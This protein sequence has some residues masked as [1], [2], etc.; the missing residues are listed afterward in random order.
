MVSNSGIWYQ[1]VSDIRYQTVSDIRYQTVSDIRY[2]TVSDIRYQTVSDIRYQ[3]VSDIRY[4][5]VSDIW[6]QTVSDIRYQTVTYCRGKVKFT[7][8]QATKAQRRSKGISPLFL[9]PRRQMGV[10]GQRHA[11][12]AL[13]PGKTHCIGGWVGPRAGLDRFGISRLHRHSIPDRPDRSESLYR[14]SY[15]TV[16]HCIK[17]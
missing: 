9:Q 1:T 16:T 15:P 2:Q 6:Y 10:G 8:E 3:T 12:A 7:P 13:P 11:P 4:Q 14:L 5:T 17:P